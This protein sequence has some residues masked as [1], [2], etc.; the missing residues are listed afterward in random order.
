VEYAKE[1]EN[2]ILIQITVHNRGQVKAPITLLP[3]L[4][5]RNTW[6]WGYEEDPIRNIYKKPSLKAVASDAIQT[7]H[8][9]ESSYYLYA[10]NP[11]ECLFTENET[12]AS[13]YTK[14]AFH[15]YVINHEKGAVNPEKVGTKGG[16]LYQFEVP[17]K[18]SHTIRLRL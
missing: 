8:S 1:S 5:F 4:W 15:R 14:D 16:F 11:D 17:P 7:S 3:T 2:D 6:S 13:P 12:N 10:E 18:S 9:A